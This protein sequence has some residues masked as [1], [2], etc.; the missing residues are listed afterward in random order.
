MALPDNILIIDIETNGLPNTS[1]LKW[2][3]Y[4]SYTDLEK[5]DNSRIVQ[6]TMM[7][8]DRHYN[9]LNLEDFIIKRDNF[10]INNSD[11]HNITNEISDSNGL[12]FIDIAQQFSNYLKQTSTIIAHNI[13]F[14]INIIKSELSRYNLQDIIEEIDKKKLA[15]SMN[16]TKMILKLPNRF[17]GIKQPSLSDLYKFNFNETMKNSHNS[18]YDVINLHKSLKNMY[19]NGVI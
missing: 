1:N 17:G 5:Y 10:S 11:F 12:P 9:E 8:C 7:L 14:D 18:K 13:N 19:C 3:Q 15:C 16:S 4:Y 6:F 2:G